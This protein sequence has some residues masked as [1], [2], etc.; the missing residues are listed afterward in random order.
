M[1]WI[2]REQLESG[3]SP[4]QVVREWRGNVSLEAIDA[5]LR[6]LDFD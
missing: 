1:I 2:V 3:M 5:V 4:Q 6:A